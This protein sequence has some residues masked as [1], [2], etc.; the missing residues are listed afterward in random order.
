MAYYDMRLRNV[1][2]QGRRVGLNQLRTIARLPALASLSPRVARDFC[3]SPVVVLVLQC[4][5]SDHRDAIPPSRPSM[6]LLTK[7]RRAVQRRLRHSSRRAAQYGSADPPSDPRESTTTEHHEPGDEDVLVWL[8]N[9]RRP[10]YRRATGRQGYLR[11]QTPVS[12]PSQLDPY[13]QLFHGQDPD[14]CKEELALRVFYWSE[15]F[16]YDE[17]AAWLAI[18]AQYDDFWTCVALR[19]AGVTPSLA[20][21]PFSRRGLPTGLNVFRA[22]VIGATEVHRVAAWAAKITAVQRSIRRS[23]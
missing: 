11:S 7:V 21:R 2:E 4:R 17:A 3:R 14:L 20:G 18:G 19:Q 9:G 23:A 15:V 22:V 16:T 13:E 5:P 12:D 10:K 1:L 8:L 6:A